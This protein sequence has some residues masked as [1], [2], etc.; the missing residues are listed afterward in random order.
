MKNLKTLSSKTLRFYYDSTANGGEPPLKTGRQPCID[1][2]PVVDFLSVLWLN[3]NAEEGLLL[4]PQ[5]F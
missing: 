1:C 3:K 2:L 5:F 4:P